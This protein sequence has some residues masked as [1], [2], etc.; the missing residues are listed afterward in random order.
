MR[1]LPSL[2]NIVVCAMIILPL[3]SAAGY[4]RTDETIFQWTAGQMGAPSD[5]PMPQIRWVTRV[6]IKQ[7]FIN[8]N[9]KAYL[10]WE[11]EYGEDRA[12]AILKVYLD[13]IVGLFDPPSN[14]VYVGSFLDACHR[15]AI[16]AHEFT[17]YLQHT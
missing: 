13:E 1:Q 11:T 10:R 5:I 16:L 17:H 6:E 9:R 2:F 3:W 8:N 4:G 14:I 15:Q 7:V 12:Q